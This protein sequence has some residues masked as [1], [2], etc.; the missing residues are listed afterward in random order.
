MRARPCRTTA[1]VDCPP[2]GELDPP[3][4]SGQPGP[5]IVGVAPMS[6]QLPAAGGS[7]P[8]TGGVQADGEGFFNDGV[9]TVTLPKKEAAKPRQVKVQVTA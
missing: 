9:L 4:I 3:P 1:S 7:Q 8:V 6:F 2:S 5:G